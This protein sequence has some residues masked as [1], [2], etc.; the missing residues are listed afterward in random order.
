MRKFFE[1]CL[2][3]F[4]KEVFFDA[5]EIVFA[6]VAK[7]RR[8]GLVTAQ[9]SCPMTAK[10]HYLLD[11]SSKVFGFIQSS[12]VLFVEDFGRKTEAKY[13]LKSSAFLFGVVAVTLL[14]SLRFTTRQRD[15]APSKQRIFL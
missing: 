4:S 14:G 13:S 12:F 1:K 7:I 8:L 5:A 6:D 2:R 10:H 3:D 11:I 9:K 15:D